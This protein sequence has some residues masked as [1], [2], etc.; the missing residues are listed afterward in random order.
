MITFIGTTLFAIF[1][2]GAGLWISVA[3]AKPHGYQP[4]GEGADPSKPPMGGS[5]A[6]H[7][8]RNKGGHNTEFQFTERPPAPAKLNQPKEPKP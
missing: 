4:K 7:Q 1:I 5:S 6:M 3:S 2:F 8:P